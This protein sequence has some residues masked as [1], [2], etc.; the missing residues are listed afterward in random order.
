MALGAQPMEIL[1]MVL[2]Q[3]VGIIATGLVLGLLI[4]FAAA[5]GVGYFLIGV[6]PT[7]PL[8]YVSVSGLLLLV[9]LVACAVPA[10][11]AM[12]LDPLVALRHE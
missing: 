5:K 2:R 7:D 4:T 11:R 10:W 9:A 3:G 6:S 8:T 1:R 12:R